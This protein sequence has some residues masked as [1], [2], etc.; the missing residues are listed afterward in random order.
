MLIYNQLI[1]DKGTKNIHWGKETSTK[2]TCERRK[3]DYLPIQHTKVNS[4]WIKDL[5][6]NPKTI[7]Y[8]GKKT[9]AICMLFDMG[10]NNILCICLLSQM[11][12][13]QN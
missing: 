10:L 2:A 8:K 1:C 12:Q 7:K 9:Q 11:K 6:G 13:K 3:M 4:K 5:N